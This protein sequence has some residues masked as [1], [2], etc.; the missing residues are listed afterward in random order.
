MALSNVFVELLNLI[1]LC[2]GLF[3]PFLRLSELLF[4]EFIIL[5]LKLLHLSFSFLLLYIP[6]NNLKK[7]LQLGILSV[8]SLGLKVTSRSTQSSPWAC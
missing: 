2:L 1:L 8:F 6:L 5:S 4:H 3:A 7:A